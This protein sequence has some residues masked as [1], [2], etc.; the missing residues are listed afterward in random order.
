MFE[1]AFSSL[2]CGHC[3]VRAAI[4]A[5]PHMSTHRYQRLLRCSWRTL[6]VH[7]RS[8]CLWILH[9]RGHRDSGT[10]G[11]HGWWI[12]P[13]RS[14]QRAYWR[15]ASWALRHRVPRVGLAPGRAHFPSSSSSASLPLSLI[16]S[17]VHTIF[18]SPAGFTF[19]FNQRFVFQIGPWPSLKPT[20]FFL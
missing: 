11:P 16:P 1:A 19:L 6:S 18:T 3:R 10:R 14:G 4:V 13:R 2:R 12:F 5:D 8:P 9:S 7:L 17:A 15:L 20:R